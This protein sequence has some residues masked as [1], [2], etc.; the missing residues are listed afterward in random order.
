MTPALTETPLGSGAF[1]LNYD[2][3]GEGKFAFAVADLKAWLDTMAI[4]KRIIITHFA[5]YSEETVAYW[6]AQGFYVA[7]ADADNDNIPQSVIERISGVD[8]VF[9]ASSPD[10]LTEWV[11]KLENRLFIACPR[12]PTQTLSAEVEDRARAKYYL[13]RFMFALPPAIQPMLNRAA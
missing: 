8:R 13:E 9:V 6:L 10:D 7:I 12:S 5:R 11:A 3:V 1:I 4:G 2:Q